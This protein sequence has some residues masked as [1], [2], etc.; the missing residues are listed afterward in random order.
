M[1]N[2]LYFMGFAN[3]AA[4]QSKDAETKVGAVIVGPDGEVRLTGYNGPPKGVKDLPD[5]L[6]R[7]GKYP[8]MSHAEQ[9][10]IAFAAREGIPTKGCTLYTTHA[11]CSS[12][13]RSIIQAGIRCVAIGEGQTSQ[14]EEDKD[15]VHAMFS[16][17]GIEI[18]VGFRNIPPRATD[19]QDQAHAGR[20]SLEASK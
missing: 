18:M 13:A 8:W 19:R 2:H 12:C 16:E 5:R 3:H 6:S 14:A 17:A 20:A 15:A 10:I 11:P 1:P 9:N 4:T 7:P